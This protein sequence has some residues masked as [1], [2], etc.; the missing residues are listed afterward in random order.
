MARQPRGERDK[1]VVI[2]KH[3]RFEA[4]HVLPHHPGKCSRLHGHSYR[5]EVAIRGA[6]Q[7]TGPARG[8]IAD[9]DEISA[10]VRP[11]VVERLD[12]SSLNDVLPNPTAEHIALWIWETL[13]QE[14]PQLD[15]IVVWETPTACAVVR[16]EDARTR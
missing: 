6:L 13:A 16:A 12:H 1:V 11:L 3:F 14:L 9:F 8:M 5:L 15:E 10:L 2:R 4:A 7:D